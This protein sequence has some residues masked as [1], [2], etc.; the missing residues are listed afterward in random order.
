MSSPNLQ[1]HLYIMLYLSLELGAQRTFISRNLLLFWEISH[2]RR[3][4]R[5]WMSPRAPFLL[6]TNGWMSRQSKAIKW[7]RRKRTGK[8]KRLIIQIVL[9]H[10]KK[11]I[12]HYNTIKLD[13]LISWNYE[14]M[15]KNISG[16]VDGGGEFSRS[17]MMSLLRVYASQQ[18]TEKY[19][20]WG[21]AK[22]HKVKWRKWFKRKENK[23]EEEIKFFDS[24]V[25]LSVV[26]IIPRAEYRDTFCA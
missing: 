17:R 23:E 24:A 21:R 22:S 19:K 11:L 7:V 4:D 14:W 6:I 16:R 15:K 8:S 3:K 20:V 25:W 5:N 2:S 9:N 13:I 26:H 1:F 10:K 18:F 12:A